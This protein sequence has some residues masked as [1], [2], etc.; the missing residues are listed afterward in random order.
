MSPS[1]TSTFLP[2]SAKAAA[3]FMAMNV[4]PLPG[5]NEV[6]RMT[7]ARPPLLASSRNSM[8]VRNTRNASFTMSRQPGLMATNGWA[9]AS[10]FFPLRTSGTSPTNGSERFSKSLRPRSLVFVFSRMKMTITGTRSPKAIATSKIFFFT[11]AVG[12]KLPV[13]GVITRVL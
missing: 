3:M 8:F 6:N 4:L 1:T 10:F 11:G 7:L 13:G 9:K 12:A 2:L 5:L